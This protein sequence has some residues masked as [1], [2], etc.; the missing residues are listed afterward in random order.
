VLSIQGSPLQFDVVY[1]QQREHVQHA[2]RCFGVAPADLDDVC[3]EVFLVVHG[4]LDGPPQDLR[5]VELWLLEI[6]RRIAAGYRRRRFR[7]SEAL[8]ADTEALVELAWPSIENEDPID[9]RLRQALARL[10]A[11]Q[12]D[13]LLLG[14]LAEVSISDLAL[15]ADCDRKTARKR[16]ASARDRL[17]R[18]LRGEAGGDSNAAGAPLA[19]EALF[20]PER[21]V[22]APLL[23][24]PGDSQLKVR[25]VTPFFAAATWQRVF[26]TIWRRA[27]LTEMEALASAASD[28]YHANGGKFA[29]LTLVEQE[30]SPPEFRSR[31]RIL[32]IV[33]GARPYLSSYAT[34]LAGG[35]SRFVVPIMNVIF[36]LT[37][38]EFPVRFFRSM[39]EASTWTMA[40]L[41]EH[42][43]DPAELARVFA[44]LR[45]LRSAQAQVPP[46]S[47]T[48]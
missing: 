38:A 47:V 9:G 39:P 27:S 6:C 13:M 20:D 35:P 45:A 26:L 14:E 24:D 23:S 43:A 36:F 12:R 2:L 19:G 37:G 42:Q 31:Q 7:R 29:Y 17:S 28:V 40:Q 21:V 22:A 15:L 25:L 8:V 18:L 46:S 5:N 4:R 48:G 16:L 33:R 11:K 34:V 1:R 41:P 44:Y 32:E 10:D 30:C 3:H